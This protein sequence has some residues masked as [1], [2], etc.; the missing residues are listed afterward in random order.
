M[1]RLVIFFV[2]AIILASF[3]AAAFKEIG[4]RDLTV[5][6]DPEDDPYFG[7][8]FDQRRNVETLIEIDR[9]RERGDALG[10]ADRAAE[11]A[12]THALAKEG[13][14]A[15]ELLRKNTLFLQKPICG[16]HTGGLRLKQPQ[17]RE[18]PFKR[19]PFAA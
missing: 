17:F 19:L 18:I 6:I 14:S 4:W 5:P 16:R 1:K 12:A 2:F 9:K 11:A 3:P 8:T 13:L 15:E 10:E 7:L